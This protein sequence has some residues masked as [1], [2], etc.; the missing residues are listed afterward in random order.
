MALMCWLCGWVSARQ[1]AWT[2]VVLAACAVV[3]MIAVQ[4]VRSYRHVRTH[5]PAEAFRWLTVV[6]VSG[7]A[8]AALGLLVVDRWLDP[9]WG[10][11]IGVLLT[12]YGT[13]VVS[14]RERHPLS[15]VVGVAA[16][17]AI[18]PL[19]Y[20]AITGVFDV[21]ALIGWAVLGGYFLLGAIFVMARFR[22]SVPALWVARLATP[23]AAVALAL[24]VPWKP[25]GW[26]L[27]IPLVILAV[28]A[29][30]FR[31]VAVPIDP[32]LIGRRELLFGAASTLIVLIGLWLR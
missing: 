32:R 26:I 1:A 28:R 17:T 24:A 10:A 29:W 23:C 27:A 25:E 4:A 13:I 6:A 3:L 11:A 31:P 19:T 22:R 2:P 12:L 21:V 5:D 16:V 15:R 14:G 20:A 18:A 7:V 9:A 30:L 8:A